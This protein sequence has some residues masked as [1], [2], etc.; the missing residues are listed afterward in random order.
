VADTIFNGRKTHTL[1]PK[2]DATE[3]KA[4]RL[5]YS[6]KQLKC[7]Y[8]VKGQFQVFENHGFNPLTV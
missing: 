7:C 8:Q 1:I 3:P 6:N 4:K 5:S 2:N